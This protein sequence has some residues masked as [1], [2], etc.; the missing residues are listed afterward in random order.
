MASVPVT[1]L[2]RA[3]FSQFLPNE[4]AIR[5]AESLQSAASSFVSGGGG[6]S[7]TPS[8]V[9]PGNY[10][11]NAN[12]GAFT[13]DINGIV[14]AAAN[15]PIAI[16]FGQV[17]GVVPIAQGGTGETTAP[18][19]INALLPSQSAGTV[20]W[21]LQSNGTVCSWQPAPGGGGGGTVTQVDGTAGEITGGPITV[22]GTLGLATTGVAAASYGSA[23]SVAQVTFD[24]KGR[25]TTASSVPISI[26]DTQV[27]GLVAALAGKA[28]DSITI[29]G[30]TSV[31]G[32]GDLT[33][34]RTLSLVNDVGSPGVLKYYGTDSG[35]TKGFFTLPT[36]GVG[37]SLV[38]STGGSLTVT[39]PAG[40]TVDV[41]IAA[42]VTPA[43]GGTG[44][45]VPFYVTNIAA[46]VALTKASLINGQPC[47]VL[48][49]T[50][51]GDGGGDTFYWDST[52]AATVNTGTC[53][54]A[55]AGGTGRWLRLIDDPGIDLVW[56]GADRSG[57]T[58]S[59]T[60][61]NDAYSYASTISSSYVRSLF[62]PAG[63][64]RVT[65]NLTDNFT[66]IRGEGY[67]S[68]KFVP[69]NATDAALTL[70]DTTGQTLPCVIQDVGFEGA[71]TLQGIGI[72]HIAGSGR[73]LVERSYIRHFDIGVNRSTGN[74]Q[75]WYRDVS[76]LGNN[77]HY[78]SVSTPTAQ[79]GSLFVEGGNYGTAEYASNYI[80]CDTGQSGQFIY[81]GVFWQGNNTGWTFFVKYAETRDSPS[82]EVRN[83]YIEQIYKSGTIT[84]DGYTSEP[85]FA[86][87]ENCGMFRVVNCATG[88]MVLINSNVETTSADLTFMNS[89]SMGRPAGQA[90]QIDA[91]STMQH[92][93]ARWTNNSNIP[94]FVHSVSNITA[95]STP[96]G[97]GSW[98]QTHQLEG[99]AKIPGATT[100]LLNDCSASITFVG[101]GSS[102]T[103]S[104]TD[105]GIGGLTTCQD[106]AIG[107]AGVSLNVESPDSGATSIA[108]GTYIAWVWVGKLLSGVAPEM[109]I[110]GSLVGG[111]QLSLRKDADNA[112]F[113]VLKGLNY[114]T[115]ACSHVALEYRTNGVAA[116]TIRMAGYAVMGFTDKQE[117]LNWL[118]STVFPT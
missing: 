100:I 54:Q 98:Y 27:V 118:N 75:E 58:D 2:N 88:G 51:A 64:Y 102:A 107:T 70:T 10:G 81:D 50:V 83:C 32:G 5:W 9:T 7:L 114:L 24:T 90:T 99:V 71:G 44:L 74:F 86:Y 6:G 72:D 117:A 37:I 31:T 46:M 96:A 1:T 69:V 56:F 12:V 112:D 19:A 57:V 33:A 45:L 13:V 30:A 28:D 49:Y 106:L 101:P 87:L 53:F 42:P 93:Q 25:A 109:Y 104:A 85:G 66:Y 84:I 89:A 78:Y 4:Q 15:T 76:M 111:T 39:N 23:S 60:A 105:S 47:I 67:L 29:T 18:N 73:A 91:N 82:I 68:S 113:Q 63:T 61:F 79:G 40:P 80:N 97:I 8:G 95:F 3:Q 34:N 36:P 62:V 21:Y 103:T 41:A 108:A 59:S 110:W 20:G 38:T 48:G 14:T 43:N 116:C 52:S 26:A 77:Y 11:D 115:S 92:Y 94:G 17:S 16:T 55:A 65:C 22:T 35:G